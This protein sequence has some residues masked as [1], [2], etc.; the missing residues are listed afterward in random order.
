MKVDE[1]TTSLMTFEL[2]L[3]NGPGKRNKS[4]ALKFSTKEVRV[5]SDGESEEYIHESPA[6]LTM[7]F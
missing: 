1:L 2:S 7:H 3:D 4:I 5:G 6:L